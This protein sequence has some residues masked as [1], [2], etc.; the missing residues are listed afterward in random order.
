MHDALRGSEE[1][2]YGIANSVKDALI[3]VDEEAK[4]TYW[5]PAAEKIFG[6]TNKEAIGKL[7]HELVV[8]NSMCVEGRERIK[9][10]VKIFGETGMGYFTVGNVELVG[11][12]R[13][14]S[15][16]PAE[17]SISPISYPAN[18]TQPG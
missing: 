13:D 11:R 8:P 12:R 16:F 18:G 17:L 9:Q 2:F 6:Y 5:N 10:S 3:L 1:R 7:V 14:G 4:V 15:E